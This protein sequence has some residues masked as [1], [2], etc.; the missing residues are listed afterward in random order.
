MI[1]V[2]IIPKPRTRN[3]IVT[4]MRTVRA[5][6]RRKKTKKT[7]VELFVSFDGIRITGKENF[8]VITHSLNR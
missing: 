1:G 6:C 5:E 4:A 3:E 7:P 8:A 2:S